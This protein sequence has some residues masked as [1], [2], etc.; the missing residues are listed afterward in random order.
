MENLNWDEL[1][2]YARKVIAE[3]DA[4]IAELVG[5]VKE[6]RLS[7]VGCDARNDIKRHH[8]DIHDIDS[9]LYRAEKYTKEIK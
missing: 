7:M 8:P 3:K 5:L 1:S 9:W 2:I 4:T 6:A